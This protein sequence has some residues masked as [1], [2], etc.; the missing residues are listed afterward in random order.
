ML[1][2]RPGKFFMILLLFS[3]FSSLWGCGKTYKPQSYQLDAGEVRALFADHTVTSRNLNTR[4]VSISYYNPDGS[5]RQI[6]HDR[7][8]TGS[9]RIEQNGQICLQM[10]SN[11]E[12]CRVVRLDNDN[13]YRK[14]KSGKLGLQPIVIYDAPNAFVRGDRLKWQVKGN[15]KRPFKTAKDLAE[16]QYLLEKSGYS[17]GSIDGIW[18]PRSRDALLNY[19]RANEFP[20]TGYPDQEVFQ[21][22]SDRI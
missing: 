9:W 6:R 1:D 14:Y 20:Q 18:G 19:Q 12:S 13:V 21:H 7:Q 17:P 22:L 16:I 8:R 4:T 2:L 11:K 15:N 5:V 10:Q 3:V